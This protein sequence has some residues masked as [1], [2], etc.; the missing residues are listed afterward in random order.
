MAS[1]KTFLL[2]YLLLLYICNNNELLSAAR[3]GI[4]GYWEILLN[5]S[6]VVA[7][8]MA[9]TNRNTVIMFDQTGAGPSAFYLQHRID[10]RRCTTSYQDINDGT[11]WAHSVEYDI[12]SNSIRPLQL[13][14]DPWCSSGVL[15]SNGT[16]IQTGGYADGYRK[17]R[18]F[19]PCSDKS[20]DWIESNSELAADR[21]YASDQIL[22]ENDRVIIVGGR[23]SFNYEFLP[24][25][26][27]EEEV[28]EL[29]LLR[30]TD[31]RRV[32]DNLYPFLHLSSDGNLFIFANQDSILLNYKN[33]KIVKQFPR[34]EGS[35]NYPSTGSSV[36][37]P[38]DHSDGF[39]KVEIMICGGASPGAFN[40]AKEGRFLNGLRTCGRMVITDENPKWEMERMPAP[41]MMNDMIILPTGD[42]LIINGALQGSA[43]WTNAINPELR[44]LLYR[45]TDTPGNR[46]SY[47]EASKIPR[48]Y[49]STAILLPD[50]RILVA[51]SNPNER[52][53]YTNVDYPTELRAEAFIPHYMD[54]FYDDQRASNLQVGEG[55]NLVRYGERF[56]LRFMLM[57]KPKNGMGF[58][59]YAPPFNTHSISMNQRMLKLE[60]VEL[61]REVNG[62]ARAHLIAPNAIAAPPGYYL[63]FVVNGGI[64]S[65]GQWLR[66]IH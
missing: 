61:V 10:G 5:S 53:S 40:A 38:L 11:C 12:L 49:H 13:Q 62:A 19:M 39:K 32:E 23:R 64:P 41:R 15:L 28:F 31:E 63:I 57:S 27:A 48:M 34:L 33:G 9:L 36:M 50:G 51:G 7:M 35:R 14:T 29:P 17:V 26:F 45:P 46:F 55:T 18:Y 30:Q 25:S 8:H 21:W 24:K 42:I 44:P 16:L 43:G 56:T 3:I 52:Y 4:G 59:V 65:E 22:P 47:L 2:L 6:G 60:C 20:C 1:I 54:S 37:L 58:H 66:F